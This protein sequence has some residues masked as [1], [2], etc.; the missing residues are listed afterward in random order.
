M[1]RFIAYTLAIALAYTVLL[2]ASCGAGERSA[3]LLVYMCGSSLESNYGI[4]SSNIDELINADIPANV[5]VVIQTGG[6]RAWQSHGIPADKLARY[7][8]RNHELTEVAQLD[9][10]SMGEASTLADFVSF[11]MKEYPAERTMLL[12]WDHGGGTLKGAC[13]DENHGSDKLTVPEMEQ[14][15]KDGLAGKRLSAIGFDACLMA[16]YEVAQATAPYADLLIASQALEMGA[17][18]DY[19]S[20]VKAL[21]QAGDSKALGQSVCDAYLAKCAASDKDASATLSAVD[22]TKFN[23]LQKA[24]ETLATDLNNETSAAD[25]RL[26]LTLAVH[27]SPSFGTDSSGGM[28]NLVDLTEIAGELAADDWTASGGQAAKPESARALVDALDSSVLYVAKGSGRSDAKGLSIYYPT[29]FDADE[30]DTY[31][32]LCESE[33]YRM[34][35]DNLFD[36]V[37]ANTISFADD[38]HVAD[39]ALHVTLTPESR[40]YVNYVCCI[41]SKRNEDGSPGVPIG[42]SYI[43]DGN[44]D[45]LEFSY[46]PTG[47]Q[48]V[49]DGHQLTYFQADHANTVDTFVTLLMVDEQMETF[50]FTG[51]KD[52]D[53]WRY[54]QMGIVHHDKAQG[55][56]GKDVTPLKTGDVIRV[57]KDTLTIGPNGPSITEAPLPAGAYTCQLIATDIFGNEAA[58]KIATFEFD[59]SRFSEGRC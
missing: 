28:G 38:G 51:K 59:G 6:C 39:G 47:K 34:L 48:V 19:A 24:F 49:L 55:V 8:V 44:W 5:R 50:R 40:K 21:S 2:L 4:A 45:T 58:S 30:I 10:A 31:L 27:S 25:G 15:L 9:P 1:R 43:E 56:A 13:F 26:A 18:W 32:S 36:D 12:L 20:L 22:L 11:G 46:A 16:D 41:L 33:N 14:G 52:G 35:I 17:G 29:R 54:E 3:T 57:G 23:A 37:P 53:G 42:L 7:E